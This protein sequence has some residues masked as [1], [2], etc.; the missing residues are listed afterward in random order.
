[1]KMHPESP[2]GP[3]HLRALAGFEKEPGWESAEALTHLSASLCW[4][5]G[6]KEKFLKTR[7]QREGLQKASRGVPCWCP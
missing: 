1:M 5:E 6:R 4:W 2:G 7:E 3:W